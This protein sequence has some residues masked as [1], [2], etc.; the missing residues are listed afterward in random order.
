MAGIGQPE[1]KKKVMKNSAFLKPK[2]ER[3]FDRSVLESQFVSEKKAAE[4]E[5][6]SSNKIKCRLGVIRA[7]AACA[8]ISTGVDLDL[9]TLKLVTGF[10]VVYG[11]ADGNEEVCG[12]ARNA[13]R[14]IVATNGDSEE[15]IA[16]LLPI[17]ETILSIGIAD[18]SVLGRLSS[19]KIPKNTSAADRRKEGVVVALGSVALHLKGSE[20]ESKIDSTNDMLISALKTPSEDVQSSVAF[21]VWQN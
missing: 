4:V 1:T 7:I 5:K 17:F 20:N 11:L 3:T 21:C 15:A 19:E 2:E 13:L 18:K 10:L 12:E 9:E 6:D 16:F 8:D 14:D